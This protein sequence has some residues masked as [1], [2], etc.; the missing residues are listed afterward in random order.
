MVKIYPAIV[1]TLF[2]ILSM[3][4]DLFWKLMNYHAHREIN[5]WILRT[6]PNQ[7][8]TIIFQLIQN[9]MEFRLVQNRSESGKYNMTLVDR[10]NKKLTYQSSFLIWTGIN[11]CYG[12]EAWISVQSV[13]TCIHITYIS[14]RGNLTKH[15]AI[16]T[17]GS[18]Y[19]CQ[20]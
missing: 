15:K 6:N 20:R 1:I 13:H 4:Q 11:S 14:P 5:F 12:T 17:Y 8:A 10:K 2:G 19:I 3:W 16:L 18:L 7:N 9:Q